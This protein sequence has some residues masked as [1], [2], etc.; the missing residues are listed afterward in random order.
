MNDEQQ[1]VQLTIYHVNSFVFALPEKPEIEV[2]IEYTQTH[3]E[4]I[5]AEA[6]L[7]SPER[8]TIR[9]LADVMEFENNDFLES[10]I[11]NKLVEAFNKSEV[12]ADSVAALVS[13]NYDYF[14]VDTSNIEQN[15]E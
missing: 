14:N 10:E 12:F 1:I 13:G 2:T 5:S 11:E 9:F 7:Y 6:W 15:G 8:R 3:D 4:T